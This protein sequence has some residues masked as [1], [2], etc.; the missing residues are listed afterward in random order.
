MI[1][2]VEHFSFDKPQS[3]EGQRAMF[4][5]VQSYAQRDYGNRVGVWRMMDVLDKYGLR[6][7]VA[8]NSDICHHEPQII[9]AGNQRRKL[10]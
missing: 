7:T 1:P 6:A 10:G 9:E 3:P 4:P 8:L 2:N 5:N